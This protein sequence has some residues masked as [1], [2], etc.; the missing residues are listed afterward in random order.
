MINFDNVTDEFIRIARE[1]VGS[2]LALIGPVSGTFPAV[3]KPRKNGPKPDYPHILLD[4]LD[5]SQTKGWLLQSGIDGNENPFW[6][7]DYTLLLQYTVFGDNAISIANQL[8]GYFR[9][10][11]VRDAIRTETKGA[12]VQTF[13]AVQSPQ[14]L[15]DKYVEA[16]LFNLTFSIV[17][18][19]VD[20]QTGVFDTFIL[21]GE[22]HR[23]Q[24][25]ENPLPLNI[26]VTSVTP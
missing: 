23:S 19:I 2:R 20:S 18:R 14:R 10:N 21:N 5:L 11:R 6:E 26:T 16:A 4:V 24:E 22:I 9:L 15:S 13:E 12:L 3:I 25:D 7:T 8:E 17:D 1:A